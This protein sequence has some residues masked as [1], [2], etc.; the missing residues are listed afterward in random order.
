MAS[1]NP[2][3]RIK[4]S[5]IFRIECH[6]GTQGVFFANLLSY[7]KPVEDALYMNIRFNIH[8]AMVRESDAPTSL[9]QNDYHGCNALA[10]AINSPKL[11]LYL[12]SCFICQRRR[13][14]RPRGGA[15]VYQLGWVKSLSPKSTGGPR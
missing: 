3:R 6:C 4:C 5:W 10:D 7:S 11:A 13:K 1:D 9:K 2:Q 14:N 12:I 8:G 15:K